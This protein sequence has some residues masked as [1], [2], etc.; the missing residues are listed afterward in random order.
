MTPLPGL[1]MPRDNFS[2]QF[3]QFGKNLTQIYDFKDTTKPSERALFKQIGKM[4]VK[5]KEGH[6]LCD[7]F[8]VNNLFF[9]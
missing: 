9:R 3:V 8:Q 6:W 4:M 2:P 5:T 1:H 7:L